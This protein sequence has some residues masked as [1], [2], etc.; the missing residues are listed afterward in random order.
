MPL[1]I[2]NITL[3]RG[4]AALVNS[5]VEVRLVT[6]VAVLVNEGVV[7]AYPQTVTTDEQGEASVTVDVPEDGGWNYKFLF[8][9]GNSRTVLIGNVG[10]INLRELLPDP[11]QP[12]AGQGA[13]LHPAMTVTFNPLLG[14]EWDEVAQLLNVRPDVSLVQPTTVTNEIQ[15]GFVHEVNTRAGDVTL[16][17]PS[18]SGV[19]EGSQYTFKVSGLGKLVLAADGN[20]LVDGRASYTLHRHRQTVTLAATAVGWAVVHEYGANGQPF[21]IGSSIIG[22]G[23]FIS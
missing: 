9:D 18:I 12:I 23:D 22:G 10:Q 14:D 20:E 13:T 21:K 2:I 6:P 8:E 16:G 11:A 17:L 15:R 1:A 5:D 3:I 19:V 4:G 7:P